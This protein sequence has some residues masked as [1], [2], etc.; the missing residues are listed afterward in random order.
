MQNVQAEIVINIIGG[1]HIILAGPIGTGK[2]ELSRLIPRTFWKQHQGYHIEEYTA[3]ADWNT[4]DVIG[5]I[6]PKMKD[7][8]PSY[9]VELGCVPSTI[10]K[11][12]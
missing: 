5:G 3:T 10:L 7:D 12:E 2:T 9:Q 11:L 1:R 4:T 6:M 8:K